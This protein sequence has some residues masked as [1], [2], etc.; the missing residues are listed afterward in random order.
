MRFYL[1]DFKCLLF[2]SYDSSYAFDFKLKNFWVGK[3][4]INR[5]SSGY[6]NFVDFLHEAKDLIKFKII[7]DEELHNLEYPYNRGFISKYNPYFE[8]NEE[9]L[10]YYKLKYGDV[11]DKLYN[12]N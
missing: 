2:D 5:A 1:V 9:E 10:F 4:S 3:N 7:T 11:F 8:L 6:Y 12:G